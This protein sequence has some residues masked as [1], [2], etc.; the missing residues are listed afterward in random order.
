METGS[1][2]GGLYYMYC[3]PSGT[4]LSKSNL[5]KYFVSKITW[6][7]R[8]GHLAEQ[9]LNILKDSLQFNTLYLPPCEICHKA[10]Q[11]RESFPLS[12]THTSTLGDLL[13]LD[14]WGPY[15]VSTVDGFKYFLT[16]VDDFTRATWVYLLKS[17]DEVFGLVFSL[18]KILQDQFSVKIKTII[19]DNGTEFI[20]NRIKNF[21]LVKGLCIKPLVL[22][23]HNKMVLWIRSINTSLMLQGL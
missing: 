8:L 9:A 20:N 2:S 23:L 10:K 19:T 3:C 13:H 18:S 12:K 7:S 6:H 1:E 15:R 17:K 16:V 11:T 22:T 21:V 14:V 4:T 5:A